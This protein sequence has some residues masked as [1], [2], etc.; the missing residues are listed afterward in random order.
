LNYINQLSSQFPIAPL[1]VVYA[2]AGTLPAACL[3]R[4][5][6]GVVDHKLYW[7]ETSDCPV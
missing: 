4:D 5:E 1:R 7:M 3:L 6:R 2:K